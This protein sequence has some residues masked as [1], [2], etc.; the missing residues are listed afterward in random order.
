MSSAHQPQSWFLAFCKGALSKC[1]RLRFDCYVAWVSRF[2]WVSA[3]LWKG[4]RQH[5]SPQWSQSNEELPSNLARGV[6][7]FV[8][9]ITGVD[10]FKE[11]I[12]WL[13]EQCANA[14]IA[15][16]WQLNK[17]NQKPVSKILDV[18]QILKCYVNVWSQLVVESGMLTYQRPRWFE[19]NCRDPASAYK[20]VII[21]AQF[22][23]SRL[24]IYGTPNLK[25]VVASRL[26]GYISVYKSLLGVRSWSRR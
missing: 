5:H 14:T 20:S 4:N 24:Q 7:L 6:P 11:R 1:T 17:L 3:W 13:A 16:F 23:A 2:D 12:E 18:N 25:C 9:R 19:K 21:A 26:R 10:R 22:C 8:C 15:R